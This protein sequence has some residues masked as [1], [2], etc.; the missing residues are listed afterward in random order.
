MSSGWLYAARPLVGE[1]LRPG[2]SVRALEEAAFVAENLSGIEVAP[3]P[4]GRVGRAAI[5]AASTNAVG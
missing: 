2:P 1:L 4:R 5:E 3:A